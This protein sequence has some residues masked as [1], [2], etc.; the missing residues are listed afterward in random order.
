V[1]LVRVL[2]FEYLSA[3]GAV[4]GGDADQDLLQQG[5]AMRDAMAA[6]LL[7]VPGVRV[8]CAGPSE[9]PG[10]AGSQVVSPLPGEGVFESLRRQAAGC[11]A[12]WAVA[13]ETD[14]LLQVMCASIG[15]PRWIGCDDQAIALAGSKRATIERLTIAGLPTPRDLAGRASHW[16]VKPDDGAGACDTR[17][18]GS[19]IAARADLHVRLEKS[20]SATIE[21]WVDGEALS[22][23]LLCGDGRGDGQVELLACNRQVIGVDAWGDVR[24]D[25]VE[26]MAIDSSDPRW[27]ALR[28][29]SERVVAA[30]PG[31]AGFV[32]IDLVWHDELGPVTIEVNPRVTSAYVGLSRRL[33]RNL[34]AEVLAMRRAAAHA[35]I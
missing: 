35:A 24:F 23:S 18:H 29:L 27:V 25:G 32:G 21:P 6:D 8:D 31:L 22:L 20:L 17:R 28:D 5:L 7:R 1:D 2:V 14:G 34:A 30:I 13:P 33:G 19:E 15:P 12:V 26:L 3:G 4:T 11:D 16:V 9:R 10:P